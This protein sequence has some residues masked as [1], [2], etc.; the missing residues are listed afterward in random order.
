MSV[1]GCPGLKQRLT[2]HGE[3]YLDVKDTISV[4]GWSLMIPDLTRH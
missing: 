1:L 4:L 3:L 2:R